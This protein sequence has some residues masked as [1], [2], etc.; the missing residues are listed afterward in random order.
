MYIKI[1]LDAKAEFF[2]KSV[3]QAGAVIKRLQHI[4][5]KI[6]EEHHLST[7]PPVKC[8]TLEFGEISLRLLCKTEKY[9]LFAPTGK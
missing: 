9:G 7:V 4:S 8:L 2:L 5:E 3:T 6:K 1:L